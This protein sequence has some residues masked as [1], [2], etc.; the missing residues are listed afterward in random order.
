[1]SG[2]TG[3]S[4][5]FSGDYRV[6]RLANRKKKKNCRMKREKGINHDFYGGGGVAGRGCISGHG[7]WERRRG[8]IGR[9]ERIKREGTDTA[10]AGVKEENGPSHRLASPFPSHCA[11]RQR[12]G[13]APAAAA[14]PC[15]PRKRKD[16]AIDR[17][18]L[19]LLMA[20]PADA[21]PSPEATSS[22][23]QGPA[24]TSTHDTGVARV[25]PILRRGRG[26]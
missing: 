25:G 7:R 21:A 10:A 3:A 23:S 4:N 8:E 15:Q 2:R 9:A 26:G 6:A 13:V 19:S 11:P 22:S 24:T 12:G 14:A 20:L 1:M 17:R 18:A 16:Q 5:N